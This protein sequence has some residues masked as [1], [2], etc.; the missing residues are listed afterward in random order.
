MRKIALLGF[1][2]LALTPAQLFAQRQLPGNTPL[3]NILKQLFLDEIVE[4]VALQVELGADL[5]TAVTSASGD[6][7]EALLL[8]QAISNQLS[9]FPLGS[10]AGG[11]SWTFD[12]ALGA[13]A[14][15]TTS[16]GPIFAERAL[17]VGKNKLNF[18]INYQRATYDEF[19]SRSLRDREI[20][21]FTV[22]TDFRLPSRPTIVGEDQLQLDLSVDTIGFFANY[23]VSDRLDLG[24]ALPLVSVDLN[25]DL[26][27]IFRDRTTG[28]ELPLDGA[29]IHRSGSGRKTG[30]GDIVVRSKYNI[31]RMKGGGL[32][33]GL[34]VRLPTGDEENLLGIPGT[35][36]KVYGVMSTAFGILSPHVNVGYTFSRGN[37]ATADPESPLLAPPDEL[38]YTAGADVAL[39]RRLTVAADIVGRTLRDIET[40][41]FGDV[42]LGPNFPEFD[43]RP[44]E[45]VNLTLASLGVKFNPHGNLLVSVNVLFPLTD[46]GLR[47]KFTPVV[48]M[49]YSF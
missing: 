45:N 11:F 18:G 4:N 28:Q 9:T 32:A 46:R 36:A 1:A 21:F 44:R 3:S 23:G 6:L 19:E 48:G 41:T 37:D 5:D 22:F 7:G 40:L 13:F 31:V 35:Q 38:N 15:G 26:R 34:D 30:L 43:L 33:A 8:T 25:A 47:D 10:S 12:P 16:F 20:T 14:R 29:E 42:G 24:V 49:D 17:T 27:F 39:T 2:L